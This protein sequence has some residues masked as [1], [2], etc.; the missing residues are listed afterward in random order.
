MLR[1]ERQALTGQGTETPIGDIFRPLE[2]GADHPQRA[3]NRFT[4]ENVARSAQPA[5]TGRTFQPGRVYEHGIPIPGKRHFG[6]TIPGLPA[7]PNQMVSN[8]EL[9]SGKIG[10]VGT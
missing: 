10:R 3:T 9:Y 6:L 2:L 5:R 4:P 1:R 7:G 8:D